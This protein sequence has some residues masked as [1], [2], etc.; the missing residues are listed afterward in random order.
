MA[1]SLVGS[2]S[3][4]A[5]EILS[6]KGKIIILIYPYFFVVEN[7]VTYKY[8]YNKKVPKISDLKSNFSAINHPRVM[9]LK[10]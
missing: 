9:M 10:T 6:R 8:L 1:H 5:P 2:P 3:Y 7:T 4:I